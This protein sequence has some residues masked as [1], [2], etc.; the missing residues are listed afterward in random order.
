MR[1]TKIRNGC[2][3]VKRK[4]GGWEISDQKTTV[5]D[6]GAVRGDSSGKSLFFFFFCHISVSLLTCI[7]PCFDIRNQYLCHKIMWHK[8]ISQEFYSK[9]F[10]S[11]SKCGDHAMSYNLIQGRN[12][13]P[14]FGD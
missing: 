10:D 9:E 12:Q 4:R 2:K 13:Y 6:G 5:F 14:D 7:Y 3:V 8:F 11:H 1:Q